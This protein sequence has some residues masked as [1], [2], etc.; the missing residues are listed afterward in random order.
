MLRPAWLPLLFFVVGGGGRWRAWEWT[1]AQ[2]GTFS[3]LSLSVAGRE[4]G[5]DVSAPSSSEI[6]M[7][8]SGSYIMFDGERTLG[9]EYFTLGWLVLVGASTRGFFI[10]KFIGAG[11]CCEELKKTHL[12]CLLF[13]SL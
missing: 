8:S 12:H 6:S 2:E 1:E 3:M 7:S 9:V 11:N 10:R 13:Q 5:C 4:V